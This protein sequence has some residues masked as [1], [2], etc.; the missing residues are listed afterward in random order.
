MDIT[1]L[2]GMPLEVILTFIVGYYVLEIVKVIFR[3]TKDAVTED[4]PRG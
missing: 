1:T 4:K 3:K 2:T